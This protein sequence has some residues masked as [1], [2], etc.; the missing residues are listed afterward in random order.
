MQSL[1]RTAEGA[2]KWAQRVLVIGCPW[3]PGDFFTKKTEAGES[4]YVPRRIIKI[5]AGE[6]RCE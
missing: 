5:K 3:P 2:R 6:T 4:N 1:G